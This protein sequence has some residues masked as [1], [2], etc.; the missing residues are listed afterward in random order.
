[1][2]TT[3]LTVSEL[4]A[5]TLAAFKKRVPALFAFS[6]DFSA[7]RGVLNQALIAKI[8]VLPT[9]ATYDATTGYA[10]GATAV[11]SLLVDVPVTMD[12]HKHVPVKITHLAQLASQRN[13]YEDMVADLAYVLGKSVVDYALTKVLA[14]NFTQSTTEA[15]VDTNRDTLG[16]VRKAMNAKGAGPQRYGIV[17]SDFAEALDADSRIASKDYYGQQ[18]GREAYLHLKGCSGFNDI[19]EYPDL[20]ANAQNLS[21]FFFDSRAI[22]V[23]T[24]IP[25]NSVEYAQSIGIPQVAATEIVTDPDTGLSLLGIKW[26]NAPTLD[27]FCTVALI[28]GV[29]AGAQGGSAGDLTDYAGYRVKT[30]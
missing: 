9:V 10:N 17:N 24:R 2:A 29:T 12:Q 27:S 23:A 8:R 14:A 13:L 7:A 22:T 30:A 3:T 26:M 5:D 15:I 21:G 18:T 4:L 1:M 25:D 11:S 16:A 28:Y 20:P 6:T 19:W